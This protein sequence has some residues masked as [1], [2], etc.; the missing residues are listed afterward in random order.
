MDDRTDVSKIAGLTGGGG[1]RNASGTRL[2]TVTNYLLGTVI[3]NGNTYK[4]LNNISINDLKIDD[5]EYKAV[6]INSSISKCELAKYLLQMRNDKEQQCVYINK[7]MKGPDVDK[8]DIS[9]VWDYD[10]RQNKT[11]FHVYS[12]NGEIVNKLKDKGQFNND[13][14][15]MVRDGLVTLL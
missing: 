11:W 1:H 13:M 9:V 15:I 2:N 14:I 3:D 10:Y 6:Y 4:C 7:Y 5:M 12:T 8:V